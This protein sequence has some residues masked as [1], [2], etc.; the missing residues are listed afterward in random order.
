MNN[1]LKTVL[2]LCV[3][4]LTSTSTYAQETATAALAPPAAEIIDVSQRNLS[5]QER[6]SRNS[7]VKIVLPGGGHGS[8][9]YIRVGLQYGVITAL[10]VVRDADVVFVQSSAGEMVPASVVY[11]HENLDF[12]VLKIPRLE[13][14]V[15]VK[16][17]TTR[18]EDLLG[19]Q[20]VY[21]GYPSSYDLLTIRGTVAGVD[22]QTIIMQS[23][24]WF[25]VSGSGVFDEDGKLMGVVSGISAE[26]GPF[27]PELLE[28]LVHVAPISSIAVE[29]ID[30]ALTAPH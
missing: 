5:R 26:R 29:T 6:L 1:V 27:G 28:T 30:R 2:A 24:G 22:P 15:A 9:T 11:R 8:G 19:R 20:G 23:F 10:H 14:R 18:L 25:G 7:A 4:T 17:R 12:A 3:A 13:T 21:T 16:Y